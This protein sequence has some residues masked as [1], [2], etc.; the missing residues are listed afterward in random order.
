MLRA[1][2]LIAFASFT[3]GQSFDAS[4][5][6][7]NFDYSTFHTVPVTL[8][9][10]SEPFDANASYLWTFSTGETQNGSVVVFEPPGHGTFKVTMQATSSSGVQARPDDRLIYI[11]EITPGNANARPE[12]SR[13]DVG[14]HAIHPGEQTFLEASIIDLDSAGPF[15]VH[16]FYLENGRPVRSSASRLAFQSAVERPDGVTISAIVTDPKGNYSFAQN[17][18]VFVLAGNLP[19]TV[20]V[21]EPKYPSHPALVDQPIRLSADGFDPEGDSISYSWRNLSTL[22]TFDGQSVTVSL[23]TPGIHTFQLFGRDNLGNID[24]VIPQFNIW[25][26]APNDFPEPS[27]AIQNP[28]LDQTIL[29][30]ESIVL[31]GFAYH[32]G[33]RIDVVWSVLDRAGTTV[34]SFNGAGPHRVFF[35]QA[36]LFEIRLDAP[37]FPSR[38]SYSNTRFIAVNDQRSTNQPPVFAP[39]D[40]FTDLVF[41]QTTQSVT[42]EASDPEGEALQ[43]I[44]FS[45]GKIFAEGAATQSVFIDVP[46][47]LF[48]QGRGFVSVVAFAKDAS[49]NYST[50]QGGFQY[51]V[52]QDIALPTVRIN[53]LDD[54]STVRLVEGQSIDLQAEVTNVANLDLTFSWYVFDQ[55]DF[56]QIFT[57][58]EQNPG[59]L[60]IDDPGLYGISLS[61]ETEDGIYT[62]A[63][64]PFIW[65]Q[66][67][68]PA[69]TPN[70]QI[71]RPLSQAVLLEAGDEIQLEGTVFE[72]QYVD[73]DSP[74]SQFNQVTNQ[75]SWSIEGPGTSENIATNEQLSYA[76]PQTGAYEIRLNTLNSLG[77]SDPT[78]DSLTV[79][80]IGPRPTD[81]LE[82]NDTRE[83]AAVIGAGTYSN[84]TVDESDPE[85]WYLFNLDLDGSAIDFEFDLGASQNDGV[86]RIY[87]GET[88]IESAR[89]GAGRK[90]RFT[91]QGSRAASYYLQVTLDQASKRPGGL[92]FGV[93]VSTAN[94]RL[95]FP[96]PKNDIVDESLLT[97]V[98]PYTDPAV[99]VFEARSKEGTTLAEV[100]LSLGPRSRTERSIE[101][102]FSDL[103]LQGLDWVRVRSDRAVVGMGLTLARDQ[104]TAVAEPAIVGNLDEL[105]VPHIAQNT[106]QWFTKAAVINNSSASTSTMFNSVAGD[107]S[108]QSIAAPYAHALFDFVNFFGGSLPAG[109]EWGKFL[110]PSA[111]PTIAGMEIFGKRD[112][113]LQ[114]AGLNLTS[115][116]LKN[117]NFFYVRKDIVFPHVAADTANFWT[118]IA[119]VNTASEPASAILRAYS[120]A[121]SVLAVENM[122]IESQGKRVGLAHQLFPGLD[123]STPI[124]WVHLETNDSVTGYELFGSNDGTDRRLAGLQAV[125]GGGT[126]LVLPKVWVEPGL[127]WTG[128][129]AV[130]LSPDSSATLTYTAYA[131]DGTERG[132]AQRTIGPLQKDVAL[133]ENLFGGFVPYGTTWI[134]LE[135]TQPVAAFELIGD[136]AGE[137]LAGVNAQ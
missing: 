110:E 100:T 117:P 96:Y 121:G 109:T 52:F 13:I 101:S 57:S 82:P 105:V 93:G 75:L 16:W 123:P 21:V 38:R 71:T 136:I 2:F 78:P 127:Y 23:E 102:L 137:F 17:A 73:F 29:T 47:D 4:I 34:A 3:F 87:R 40:E 51:I 32:S 6:S 95:I 20:R 106:A 72:P 41:N 54:L 19:P 15:A 11:Q 85:D 132:S 125:A 80:V 69:L 119:F 86:L 27:L 33:S 68:D 31:S 113:N 126:T 60:R 14:Q 9:A 64:S 124:S 111:S 104:K 63:N 99:I 88:V 58:T 59:R 1:F 103:E 39:Q 48:F 120:A 114:V 90:N 28:L 55:H 18:E 65:L 118:G 26:Y 44:W 66:V 108:V 94:P 7:P 83:Q 81:S 8:I 36:G 22:E 131:D 133:A 91:F 67:Y 37:E 92:D 43:Y 89:L 10:Q 49:G 30:D 130:N 70:T 53:E 35:D 112:G 5:I 12:I 115:D 129:A 45:D 84:L 134:L 135:S 56:R 62:S 76:F 128:I 79:T 46:D 98:N 24:P 42:L 77:L 74:Y 97:V 61:I 107:W 50:N 116:R 25:V 122:N